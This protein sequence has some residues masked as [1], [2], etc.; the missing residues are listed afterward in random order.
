MAPIL[1]IDLT[2]EIDPFVMRVIYA[3]HEVLSI[4]RKNYN[5]QF[6]LSPNDIY[7][8]INSISRILNSPIFT[9]NDDFLHE[10]CGILPYRPRKMMIKSEIGRDELRR[11]DCIITIGLNRDESGFLSWYKRNHPSGKIIAM[12]EIVPKFLDR[13]DYF[14]KGDMEKNIRFL[15]EILSDNL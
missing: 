7:P 9:E 15:G 11:L 5:N 13:W 14:V 10:R 3:P 6:N 8:L 12:G 4:L 2:K 1:G